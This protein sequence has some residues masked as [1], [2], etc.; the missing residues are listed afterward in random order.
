MLN[1]AEAITDPDEIELASMESEVTFLG[2][3]LSECIVQIDAESAKYLRVVHRTALEL[4]TQNRF[5][6]EIGGFWLTTEQIAQLRSLSEYYP[7][8]EAPLVARAIEAYLKGQLS[9]D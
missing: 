3:A 5:G 9:T 8:N 7:L 2:L 4:A 1:Q 6:V